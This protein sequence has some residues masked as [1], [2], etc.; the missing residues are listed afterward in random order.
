MHSY[1]VI[2]SKINRM[3]NNYLIINRKHNT[4]IM[5]CYQLKLHE[6]LRYCKPS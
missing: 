4:K 3:H 1:T 2:I 5:H 6:V